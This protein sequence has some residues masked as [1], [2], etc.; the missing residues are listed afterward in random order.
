MTDQP[1]PCAHSWDVLE[2]TVEE[3]A[4]LDFSQYVTAQQLAEFRA[5]QPITNLLLVCHKCGQREHEQMRGRS[6]VLP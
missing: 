6:V 4:R 3:P 1:A 2:R 5:Q